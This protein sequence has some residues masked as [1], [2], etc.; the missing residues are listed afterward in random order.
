[1][2][3][4]FA[5]NANNAGSGVDSFADFSTANFD[6]PTPGMKF[7]LCTKVNFLFDIFLSSAMWDTGVPGFCSLDP[8]PLPQTP[9]SST[10]Q[11]LLACST[12]S[13]NP[14]KRIET[15]FNDPAMLRPPPGYVP[16]LFLIPSSP[17][18]K[19]FSF[20]PIRGTNP[21]R[22]QSLVQRTSRSPKLSSDFDVPTHPPAVPPE[23]PP[24]IP[25]KPP[26][27][28]RKLALSFPSKK[29]D[30]ANCV[31]VSRCRDGEIAPVVERSLKPKLAPKHMNPSLP[32]LRKL[33]PD[34]VVGTS[35]SPSTN[36]FFPEFC[37]SSP[38]HFDE[39]S[40]YRLGEEFFASLFTSDDR[41]SLQENG[42]NEIE[43][44]FRKS[45]TFL[46]NLPSGTENRP[47]PN[48]R[49]ALTRLPTLTTNMSLTDPI[50]SRPP[51]GIASSSTASLSGGQQPLAKKNQEAQDKY[52][53]LKDLDDIFRT[54]VV[55]QEGEGKHT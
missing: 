38:I 28:R 42:K 41:K 51:A 50:P 53:A 16:S 25:P 45:V 37:P 29:N 49:N 33:C 6:T 35:P 10:N 20:N 12:K 3:D 1:M 24:K 13:I 40:A 46:D 14:S 32:N 17:T 55:V 21:A 31:S 27:I 26:F 9:P 54:S 19:V 39:P 11:T 4:P 36:P 48:N 30:Y 5:S 22:P 15:K 8:A 18:Q 2:S 47:G 34:E 23:I 44:K 52:A 43:V 7:D